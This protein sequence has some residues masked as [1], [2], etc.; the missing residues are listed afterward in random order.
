MEAITSYLG[1]G[2]NMGQRRDN[3]ERA[4][5]LLLASKF[6][7][8]LRSSSVYETAPWGYT[9]QPDFLNLVLEA[10]TA[11]PPGGLLE[12]VKGLERKMGREPGRRFGPRIIDVD[13]LLYGELTLDRADLQIPHPR[14]HQRSFVLVPLAEL[15]PGLV[16]PTIGL[17]MAKLA[18]LVEDN[19]GVKLWGPPLE[20]TSGDPSAE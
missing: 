3:L 16:H 6:I 1:L 4:A 15:T 12:K 7:Q 20:L 13:I 19:D 18:G 2:S 9:D 5:R 11:L 17:T 10:H 14:L 8:P